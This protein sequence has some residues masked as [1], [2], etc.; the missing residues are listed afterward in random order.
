MN[1]E[2]ANLHPLVRLRKRFKPYYQP[3]WGPI[4]NF[5]DKIT[6]TSSKQHW[7]RVVMDA[8][9]KRLVKGLNPA[10]LKVLE[11]SGDDWA[12]K[13]AFNSFRAAKFPDF[14]ICRDTSDEQYDLII[15]EQVFEHLPSPSRAIKNVLAML[16]DDGAFLI[17]LPFLIRYHGCP[18][19]FSRWTEGGIRNLLVE[20]GFPLEGIV[21][22]SW[23]NKACLKANLVK[24]TRYRPWLHSLKN[25]PTYPLSVWALARKNSK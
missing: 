18:D 4:R 21:S 14:D 1:A 17:T 9:T 20:H 24:W 15:A 2:Y 10:A 6:F 12:S 22:G 11:I 3:V 19:D 5:I 16:K 8:E 25:N 7:V 13:F 23:G